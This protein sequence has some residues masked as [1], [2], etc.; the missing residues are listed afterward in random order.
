MSGLL[1]LSL[2]AAPALATTCPN[3]GPPEPFE[4]ES[5]P[6]EVS[7]IA[8][9]QV[10]SGVF[11]AL[12]DHGNAAELHGFERTGEYRG[13]YPVAPATNTDWED[14]AAAPCPDGSPCLYIGDIGDNDRV[15]QSISVILVPEPSAD[16]ETLEPIATWEAEYPDGPHD[17]ETL[18]VHPC[19]GAIY[20]ITKEI[21]ASVYRFPPDTGKGVVTL[22]PVA[23]L[24][25]DVGA[26]LTGGAWDEHG[27]R[28][29]V[30]TI[31]A[32]WQWE[33][34]PGDRDAHWGDDPRKLN[35]EPIDE[36]LGEGVTFADD[37]AIVTGSE[38]A[39]MLGHVLLCA[40]EIPPDDVCVFEPIYEVR[41]CGCDQGRV[42]PGLLALA[43][44]A[45][46]AA[47]RPARRCRPRDPR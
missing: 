20:I 22:E 45:V 7:G 42:Q 40:D 24:D 38:G 21:P 39:P 46:M 15:R 43:A 37:A 19:D 26:G 17:A 8:A 41:G 32:N 28:L 23:T 10:R 6:T 29:V 31:D 18:L 9:S 16:G 35:G 44:V 2:G 13:R 27:E 12:A 11:L 1:L 14:L 25:L 36:P 47:G 4:V 33:T 5:M 30:R 34:D 3:Y